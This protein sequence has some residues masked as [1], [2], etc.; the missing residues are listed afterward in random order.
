EQYFGEKSGISYCELKHAI[1]ESLMLHG[2]ICIGD[3]IPWLKRFDLQGYEK[4][5]KHAQRKLDTYMQIIVEKHRE[6]ESNKDEDQMDFIDVLI[7]EEKDEAI[8]DKDAFVKATAMIMLLGGTDTSSVALEWALSLLLSHPHALEKAQDEL[9]SKIGR[10]RVVVESDI[11][12][13]NYL[14]AIM[15]ETLRLHPPA[16]LLVPHQ[17]T[18]ACIVGGFHIPAGTTLIIN[19]WVI[20]RDEKVWNRPLE[21]IPERFMEVGGGDRGIGNIY[22]IENEFGMI[23]FGAG[24]R[25]C[26]GYSLAMCTMHITLARLLQGFN[27]FAPDE[28]KIDMNEGVGA[29]MPRAVPLKVIVQPRLHHGLY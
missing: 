19:A 29:T 21:F 20:H 24:R 13:L 25:G 1:E 9:D 17:S 11:R 5:M 7:S 14:Q 27:W 10:N 4:A 16:P 8:S 28:K 22:K 15:K 3:Y 18:E 26:P 12:Q 2:A 23:P 6:N